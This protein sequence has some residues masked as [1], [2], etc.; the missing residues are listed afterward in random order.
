MINLTKRAILDGTLSREEQQ[1]IASMIAQLGDAKMTS[2][3]HGYLLGTDETILE[4]ALRGAANYT[5]KSQASSAIAI[6]D[7]VLAANRDYN[8]VV[9]G[10]VI[11]MRER[12][13]RLTIKQLGEMVGAATAS[14]FKNVWGH[15]DARKFEILKA[16]LEIFI[17]RLKRI[18]TPE[19]DF[20]V[21][22]EWAR[23]AQLSNKAQDPVGKIKDI[24]IATFQHLRMTFGADTIKPDLR[25]KNVLEQEF[26]LRLSD[27]DSV[28][29]VEQMAKIVGRTPLLIDQI[30]VK[31]GSGYYYRTQADAVRV[32]VVHIVRKLKK[33]KMPIEKIA[34][35]TGWSTRD[36]EGA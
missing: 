13:G 26:D 24:G 2:T 27:R 25:V 11:A 20:L 34:E 6:M 35:V 5:T 22:S 18:D 14:E 15:D 32:A 23:T 7:V 28:L 17:P 8:R 21:V 33:M 19:N 29:V 4:A 1:S 9:K 36:I 30:F 12:F 10:H 31:Y 16:L 3:S